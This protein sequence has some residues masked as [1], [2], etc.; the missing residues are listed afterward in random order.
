MYSCLLVFFVSSSSLHP[1]LGLLTG[2]QPCALPICC[3]FF[4]L[5]QKPAY[6]VRISDWSS[7]VCSSDL[8]TSWSR[9]FSNIGRQRAIRSSLGIDSALSIASLMSSGE[10]R[11]G[12]E[13]VG[14]C[15]SRVSPYH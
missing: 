15:R 5:K 1:C 4:F 6:E 12:K 11:V 8:T 9:T 7:D 14:T 3:R 2:V 13:C 10:R